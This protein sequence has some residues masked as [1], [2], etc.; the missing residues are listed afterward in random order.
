MR[1]LKENRL[2]LLS[3]PLG[4][5]EP[6]PGGLGLYL[7]DTRFVCRLDLR[8]D[9]RRPV[10]A[11]NGRSQG[12]ARSDSIVLAL[13]TAPGLRLR[14]GR[15]LGSGLREELTVARSGPSGREARVRLTI[16]FDAADIFEL[17]GYRRRQ[18]GEL[19]P[20]WLTP[21]GARFGYLGLDHR[22]RLLDVEIESPAGWTMATSVR[23]AGRESVATI[24]WR[25]HLEPGEGSRAIWRLNPAELDVASRAEADRRMARPR[26]AVRRSSNSRPG[27]R[28]VS[29]RIDD[30]TIQRVVD[31][32]LAD[33]EMLSEDGPGP[34]QRFLAAG[35]PWFAALFGRDSLLAAGEAI[36]FRP[37]LAVDA[38]TVLA[39]R[40]AARVDPAFAAEP[41]QILHELRTGE[42]ASLGEVPFGSW[43][44]SVDATPLWLVL[45]AEADGWLRDRDLVDR[46]WPHALR[47][48]A[49]IDARLSKDPAGFLRYDGRPGALANEGW[50]DSP[51]AIRDRSGAIVQGPIALAE[52]QGYVHEAWARL[53][54]IAFARGDRDLGRTLAA[55]ARGL[56]ARFGPA[57]WVA[58]R[59]FLAMAIGAAGQ[60][61]DAV[62]SNP[63]QALSSGILDRRTAASVARRILAPDMD[64]GWGIRT[65][66]ASE[67]AFDPAGY[68]TGS[69]WP[70]DTALITAGLRRA[71]FD[72]AAIGVADRLL[73]AAASLPEYRLPELL[74]GDQRSPTEAAPGLVAGACPVQAWASAAPLH[75]LRTLLG[76]RPDARANR[77]AMERPTLPSA[78][79]RV[80][81]GGL[82]VGSARLDLDIRRT[83]RGVTARAVR[84]EGIAELV[85]T[86]R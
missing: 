36:A 23:R 78:V 60:L 82:A 27:P 5:V 26:L 81:L 53:S 86:S 40:Q 79:S 38:L 46:L 37:D 59:T 2:R 19:L 77:L 55:Q 49:W 24:D 9:G 7:G 10:L 33:L 22:L 20:A 44:G 6:A 51:D 56:R 48:L 66:A 57:F 21:Y 47:A 28:A 31:R 50:K 1:L 72:Q 29:I 41:G 83:R 58:D 65:L 54:A 68:H 15:T 16:G 8:I 52:V 11:P 64:S 32:A 71:G 85:T 17:R 35:L 43:F 42:M 70:H 61:A 69:V 4:E 34:G 30:P 45:L 76:L 18:R 62:A 25:I 67:P 13:P 75:L 39:E 14:R 63:G 73:Q 74:R 84:A 80:E 12:P 3:D